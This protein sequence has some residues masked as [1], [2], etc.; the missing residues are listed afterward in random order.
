MTIRTLIVD[1]EAHARARIRHAIKDEP[2]FALVGECA[3]GRVA[4]EAIQDLLNFWKNFVNFMI[5]FVIY[6]LPVLVTIGIP[7]YLAFL[8]L[9]W[10]FRKMRG[11]KK[12]AEPQQVEEKK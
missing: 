9:R 1:D 10:F 12:K 8:G 11:T 4:L 2:D 3:N 7:F 5:R 6:T